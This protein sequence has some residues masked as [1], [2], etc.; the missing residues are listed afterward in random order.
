MKMVLLSV[1]GVTLLQLGE[2]AGSQLPAWSAGVFLPAPRAGRRQ[3]RAESV[4]T[5]HGSSPVCRWVSMPVPAPGGPQSQIPALPL[6]R[7]TLMNP[8]TAA[9]VGEGNM[10]KMKESGESGCF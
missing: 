2:V 8:Q 7:R 9:K 4:S 5:L 3:E 6:F 10:E 1:S